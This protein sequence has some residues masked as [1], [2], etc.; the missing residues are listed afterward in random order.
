MI[1]SKNKIKQKNSFLIKVWSA[2]KTGVVTL[3]F[4]VLLFACFIVVFTLNGSKKPGALTSEAGL[5][6]GSTASTSSWLRYGSQYQNPISTNSDQTTTPPVAEEVA[7][8]DMNQTMQTSS[9]NSST[10][11][12]CPVQTVRD[13][14]KDLPVTMYK[15]DVYSYS[16]YYPPAFKLVSSDPSL[17]AVAPYGVRGLKALGSSGSVDISGSYTAYFDPETSTEPFYGSTRVLKTCPLLPSTV[18][19]G[20]ALTVPNITGVQGYYYENGKWVWDSRTTPAV[21]KKGGYLIIYG[22]GFESPVVKSD[23]PNHNWIVEWWSP[24]QINVKADVQAPWGYLIQ[25]VNANGKSSMYKSVQVN[26]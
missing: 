10:T 7:T 3:G 23:N 6:S 21:T 4:A 18:T 13:R 16:I 24:N 5:F 2:H 25:V 12:T 19:L 26:P 1:Q 15:N 14:L 8:Q 11:F 9:T 22:E 20:P 17:I